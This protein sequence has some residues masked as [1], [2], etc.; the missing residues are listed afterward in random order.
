MQH[1]LL[2][3]LLSLTLLP[4]L[5]F[6]VQTDGNPRVAK[7][8]SRR[9]ALEGLKIH[10]DRWPDASSLRA[11]AEDAIRL[12]RARTE[13]EEALALYDWIAR[14]MTIGGSPHEGAPGR[15]VYVLDTLKML[16]VYGNH[17]CDGQAR[18]Y[19]TMWRS[20]GRQARRLYIPMRHHTIAELWWRDTDGQERW[21]VLDVNNGWYVRNAAGWIASSEDIERDPLLVLAAAQDLKMRT[22]GWLRTH[23]TP[24]PE[25]RMGIHL[26]R[27]E[28]YS[29]LW[30]N[31]GIYYVNPR[32]RASVS[33]DSPLYK[34]GGAYARFIGGGEMIFAPD[35][36]HSAWADDLAEEPTNAKLLAERI[37][38]AAASRPAVFTYRFDF[39]YLIADAVIEGAAFR[40]DSKASAAIS[41]STDEGKS[42][43]AAWNA[44]DTGRNRVK[45]SLGVEREKAGQPSVLGLYSYLIRFELQ[46]DPSQTA[47]SDLKFTHRTMMNKMTLPNLQP[48]WNRFKV[49]AQ[50]MSPGTALEIVLEWADKGGLQR[51]ERIADR[52]P[53]EFEVFANTSGGAT[54]QMRALRFEAIA[55]REEVTEKSPPPLV[56]RLKSGSQA[57]R[58]LTIIEAG[59]SKQA[60]AVRPLIEILQGEDQE[61]RYWA[62][63]ALGKIGDPQAAPALIAAVRDPYEAVRMSASVALGDLKSKEAV[64]VLSELVSGK[65][66]VG[67]GYALFVPEDVGAA[68]WMAAQALG[69]IGDARAVPVLA[70]TVVD[71]GGDLGLY[72]AK[73]LGELG[74]RRAVPALIEA[75]K[76]GD[77]PAL[78][79]IVE[80]LGRIGDVSAAPVLIGLLVTGKE[81]AR[82]AAAVALGQLRAPGA[83]AAL[84]KVSE[85][86]PRSYVREA[87]AK[88]LEAISKNQ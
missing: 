29:L 71:A 67:K 4:G 36:S 80:A 52:L 62:A 86:D 45:L 49:T 17:W 25:H 40:S 42:W 47:F 46:G 68:R 22:K 13:E 26:R 88:S 19:E 20:L 27:G 48:G 12:Q 7:R 76:K 64:P 39:P 41:F 78:R 14:V 32:T 53:F 38:P 84:K 77:E 82:L 58:V 2:T 30:D 9:P 18:I 57:D 44:A 75:A 5:A 74:N 21:H 24:P 69:R 16:N 51:A 63:D 87:A 1:I 60:T 15:E 3:M 61:L 34:P 43:T 59:S 81:D 8:L 54:A 35:L 66:P 56:E 28:S 6:A 73:A 37:T 23:L 50:A 10:N 85:S 72:I 31:G 11:F 79:G 33:A 55:L 65:I 83:V 70:A